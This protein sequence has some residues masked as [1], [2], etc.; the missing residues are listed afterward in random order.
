MSS[1]PGDGNT[2][3]GKDDSSGEDTFEI[4]KARQ[5]IT[6]RSVTLSTLLKDKIIEPG[7]GVLSIDYLGQKFVADLLP[8]GKIKGMQ[9]TELFLTPSAW[10]IHCKKMVN[11]DKK[12]GC[13]WASV[14]YRGHKLDVWKSRWCRKQR[15]SS[16]Y[17]SLSQKSP[18]SHRANSPY[19]STNQKSPAS[20]RSNSPYASTN[21]KSPA[22]YRSNSPFLSGS[23]KSPARSNSPYTSVVQR[24]SS[25]NVPSSP[26][27]SVGENG[28]NGD[29][30]SRGTT[31]NL[32]EDVKAENG[33][34]DLMPYPAHMSPLKNGSSKSLY[35]VYKD[36]IQE[37]ALN[38]SMSGPHA[39]KAASEIEVDENKPAFVDKIHMPGLQSLTCRP[40][41]KYSTLG[42][43]S[44]DIDPNILIEC[45]RFS[46]Y[47]KI[48]PFTV[49]ITTNAMIVM[50]FHCHMT[51]SEVVGYL[52]GRW[53]PQQQHITILEAFPCRCRLGDKDRAPSTED[54]VCFPMSYLFSH[55]TVV[56]FLFV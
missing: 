19:T 46:N 52:G 39:K 30:G 28:V 33:K 41:I 40:S 11:P 31:P 54:E 49:T 9:S 24:T 12:S 42:K 45:E 53:D 18:A 15:P 10:A 13:G 38:L 47:N 6:G 3:E 51:T 50:D 44:N 25:P 2:D 43:R 7:E 37:E 8:N 36:T 4:D 1:K 48:Q 55:Q 56:Q 20:Y 34:Y 35:S 21:Q 16:P 32:N 17:A 23:Q 26:L 14:K 22:S 29:H 5:A 27:S